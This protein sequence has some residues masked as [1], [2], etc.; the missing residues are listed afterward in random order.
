ML[1]AHAKTARIRDR[2]P[3]ARG[4]GQTLLLGSLFALWYFFNIYF[5]IANKQVLKVFTVPISC[6]PLVASYKG[7]LQLLDDLK[8]DVPATSSRVNAERDE[9][10]MKVLSCVAKAHEKLG[11]AQEAK[12]ASR[13]CDKIQKR[14]SEYK[15]RARK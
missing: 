2:E 9:R 7:A 3:G 13:A 6:T 12:D 11:N 14:L 1:E 10:R 8:R 5:N 4:W 15:R